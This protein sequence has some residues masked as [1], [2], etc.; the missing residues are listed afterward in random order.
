[1]DR[2]FG[3]VEHAVVEDRTVTIK[4]MHETDGR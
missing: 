4:V 2:G 3:K 1:M